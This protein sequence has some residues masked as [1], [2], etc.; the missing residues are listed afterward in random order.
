[1]AA[2]DLARRLVESPH[3]RWMPGMLVA[4]DCPQRVMH[5]ERPGYAEAARWEPRLYPSGRQRDPVWS[6]GVFGPLPGGGDLPVLSDPATEGCLLRLA[7]DAWDSEVDVEGYGTHS[8]CVVVGYDTESRAFRGAT[9]G[10]ALAHAIL[11]AGE[12]RDA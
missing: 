10:E 12:V 7:R 9:L 6:T 2:D 1:V 8:V 5:V 11:A 3:W 4:S